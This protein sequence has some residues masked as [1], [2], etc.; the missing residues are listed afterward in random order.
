M[1]ILSYQSNLKTMVWPHGKRTQLQRCPLTIARLHGLRAWAR[2]P[3]P[4]PQPVGKVPITRVWL[5]MPSPAPRW[6]GGS[7]L[8]TC[9]SSWDGRG[10][11]RGVSATWAPRWREWRWGVAGWGVSQG[12]G[13]KS[14]KETERVSKERKSPLLF[15]YFLLGPAECD[16]KVWYYWD[17]QSQRIAWV[18]A[19]PFWVLQILVYLSKNPL[20]LMVVSST[21]NQTKKKS[22]MGFK[23][24]HVIS[25]MSWKESFRFPLKIWGKSNHDGPC[26]QCQ[27]VLVS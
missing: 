6:G 18:S 23:T 13:L 26:V 7:G 12:G 20:L 1:Q 11:A 8:A 2:R 16:C 4:L 22:C 5:S 21:E 15:G 14:R 3:S 10:P 27:Q 9:S 19:F 25:E 24:A 17:R